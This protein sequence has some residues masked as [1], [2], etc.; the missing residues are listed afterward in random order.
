MGINY[1]Q[2]T[3]FTEYTKRYKA[4]FLYPPPQINICFGKQDTTITELNRKI[5]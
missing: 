2:G 5:R 3:V 4:R 1:V